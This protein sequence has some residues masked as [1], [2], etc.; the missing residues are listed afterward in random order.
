VDKP[1]TAKSVSRAHEA[2]FAFFEGIPKTIVY[3][4]DRTMLVD[5]NMGDIILTSTFREYIHSRS[6]KL[7]F[8]RKSDPESKGKVENVVGYVKKNFLYNRAYYDLETLNTEALSWLGRTANFLEHNAT[9][10]SPQTE[11][12]I[13]KKHLNPYTPLIMETEDNKRYTLRKNNTIA[14]KSNFYTLPIGTYQHPG[15]QVIVEEKEKMVEIYNLKKE[16][17]CTHELCHQQGQIIANT[18]HRR[19]NTK[20]IDEM[21]GTAA[22]CFTNGVSAREYLLKI[23]EKYPRYTRDHLQV[24]IKA[25]KDVDVAKPVADKALDFCLNNTLFS[26]HEFSQVLYVILMETMVPEKKQP[27]IKLL[28]ENN[29]EKANQSPQLSNLIDYENI[30]NL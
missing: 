22:L 12:L 3:D 4:Q 29:L 21:M 13:E 18:S 20:S 14:Y 26:G 24:M 27:P 23:R 6:F 10:K 28:D 7:H 11:Y 25:L 17:I 2:A 30:I 8:C 16:L 9:K 15:T 19:D 1:F 5:E